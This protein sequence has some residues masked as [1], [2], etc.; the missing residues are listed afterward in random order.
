M[1]GWFQIDDVREQLEVSSATAKNIVD[2]MVRVKIL[3]ELTK[4]K[5][6]RFNNLKLL[7]ARLPVFPLIVWVKLVFKSSASFKI[8]ILCLA[9]C[10]T[11]LRKN[12]NQSKK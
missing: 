10:S 8:S 12:N 1:G 6:N 5:R 2:D 11:P 3:K 9:V 4:N 7:F